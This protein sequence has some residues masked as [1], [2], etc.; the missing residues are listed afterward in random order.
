[1]ETPL[2]HQT[3]LA[4]E[5]V[6]SYVRR[7]EVIAPPVN[8]AQTEM[9]ERA[10]VFVSLKIKGRLR[11]CIGTFAP[12]TEN[13]ASE[14]IRNAIAAA[15]QD[16]RFTP[17]IPGELGE[18]TYSVD[19]LSP[20]EKVNSISELDPERYGV[21]VTQG[22]KRGLLLPALEGVN[23]VDEQLRITKAKAGIHPEDNNV[24]ILRFEVRRYK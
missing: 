15:T 17:V 18:I 8:P 13:T 19:I 1:M 10:G 12:T 9:S 6:E 3:R 21:I 5:A 2:S 14:I 24:E 4:K 22:H 23:T 7:H 11:G 16:P 20:P